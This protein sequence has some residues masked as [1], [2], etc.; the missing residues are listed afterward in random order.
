MP[1]PERHAAPNMRAGCS[2]QADLE[3]CIQETLCRNFGT[4]FQ[5]VG[6]NPDA[7]MATSPSERFLRETLSLFEVFRMFPDD[8]TAERWFIQQ[9]WPDGIICV[10]CGSD[11]VNARTKH[12]T[13]PHRC[14]TCD[15][16]F[17]VRIGTV[18]ECSKLGYREWILACY[19]MSTHPKGVSSMQL[20]RDLGITQKSAWHLA[21]R[22]RAAWQDETTAGLFGGPVEVDETYIG[23]KEKNKHACKKLRAGRGTVGKTPVVGIKDRETNQIR[24]EGVSSTDGATLKRFVTE[25]T[26]EGAKIY[27]DSAAAYRG[28]PNHEYVNHSAGEYVRDEVHTNGMESFWALLKRGYHGTYH[29]MSRKHRMRYIAECMARHNLRPF[30]IVERLKRMVAFMVGK[31]LRYADL[32]KPI[33]L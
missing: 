23:G 19:L 8:T 17:S 29:Y 5:Y 10:H 6:E 15:K 18:M 13:M 28:L 20:H 26:Q 11:N 27:T 30:S 24:A 9:R 31:R 33:P 2:A 14:R 4:I 32:I 12:K 1:K 25:H 22:I 16:R 21:H 7:T 3:A